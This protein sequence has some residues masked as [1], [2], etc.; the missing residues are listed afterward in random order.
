MIVGKEHIPTL[1]KYDKAVALES[2]TDESKRTIVACK[3]NEL[4]YKDQ[5]LLI[6]VDSMSGNCF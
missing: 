1:S 6:S 3:N 4:V 5:L 2:Q